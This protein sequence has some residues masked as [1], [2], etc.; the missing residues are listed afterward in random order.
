MKPTVSHKTQKI[1]VGTI[2]TSHKGRKTLDILD[3]TLTKNTMDIYV[4]LNA[5][6]KTQAL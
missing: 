4:P 2:A 6:K 1:T 3:E 5:T